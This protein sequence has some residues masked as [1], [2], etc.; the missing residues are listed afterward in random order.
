[1]RKPRHSLEIIGDSTVYR[2]SHNCNATMLLLTPSRRYAV[3]VGTAGT[4]RRHLQRNENTSKRLHREL[5]FHRGPGCRAIAHICFVKLVRPVP[6]RTACFVIVGVDLG[7]GVHQ[8]P[9]LNVV[10][11]GGK[12]HEVSVSQCHSWSTEPYVVVMPP[13]KS[14][15]GRGNLFQRLLHGWILG[16]EKKWWR[17]TDRVQ[18]SRAYSRSIWAVCLV[19]ILGTT[20][21]RAADEQ[22]WPFVPEK[23]FH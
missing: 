18:Q 4:D 14:K 1:M 16:T 15:E 10:V 3:P 17:W 9:R 5:Q 23:G 13:R 8:G 20:D 6:K 11:M 19:K 22:H 21:P 2:K 7:E 12:W